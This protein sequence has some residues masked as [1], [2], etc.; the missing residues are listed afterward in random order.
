[1]PGAGGDGNGM[2]IKDHDGVFG[3]M[4]ISLVE[5]T[6]IYMSLKTIKLKT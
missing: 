2:T 1:M 6:G 3:I 5:V 4:D